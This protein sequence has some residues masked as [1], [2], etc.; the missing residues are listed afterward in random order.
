MWNGRLRISAVL[1]LGIP[2]VG[3]LPTRAQAPTL[4]VASIKPSK[5]DNYSS[6][7]IKTGNG[8]I[9]AR[10]VTLKRC[11]IGAYGVGLH[12]IVGPDWLDSDHFDISA[13][14][15]QPTN[16]DD[17]L[18]LML[19]ALLA[20]RFK[21]AFHR[22]TKTMAAYVLEVAKNGPKLE[23]AAGGE[24]STN[25]NGS[26]SVISIDARNEDVNQFAR[27]LAR[28][29]DLPVVNQTGV[30]G[31]YNF[32]LHWTPDSALGDSN[33][34]SL[35]IFT[36]IQEQLGLRLHAAKAPVEVLVIDHVERIPT[37]N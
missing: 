18:M 10:G 5:D 23:K 32:K 30:A 16:S 24:A 1:L 31:L 14:A 21:L 15:E 17:Q 36:A 19:Q 8:R 28:R 11:I 34:E 9:E 20:D 22:E 37:E 3:V 7:G 27:V 13:K 25:T 35:S 4:E 12:Q 29:M 2:F 26:H 33:S 6:G